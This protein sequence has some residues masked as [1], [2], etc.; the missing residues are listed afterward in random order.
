MLEVLALPATAAPA[1]AE[2]M[3][4]GDG[5]EI[6]ALLTCRFARAGA[7][8]TEVASTERSRIH[9]ETNLR[10]FADG[11]R[12]LRTIGREFLR[13]GGLAAMPG[14]ATN[15]EAPV[16]THTSGAAPRRLRA[17]PPRVA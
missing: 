16:D 7:A 14:R 4:W 13:P 12:V 15:A 10:T 11:F 3:V 9:G 2:G 17:V 8:V 5:F 1:P 6:E